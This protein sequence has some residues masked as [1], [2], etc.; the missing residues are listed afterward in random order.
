M[1]TLKPGSGYAEVTAGARG[2]WSGEAVGF[3]RGEVGWKP[4]DH[5]GLFGFGEATFGGSL[6][7]WQAGLG[8]RVTW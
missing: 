4:L 8:A 3:V 2:L 6:P 7:G 5:V 1:D